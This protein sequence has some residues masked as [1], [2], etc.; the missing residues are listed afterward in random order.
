MTPSLPPPADCSQRF[1]SCR[2]VLAGER[3]NKL[4]A[5]DGAA[6]CSSARRRSG[7]RAVS[8]SVVLRRKRS[9]ARKSAGVSCDNRLMR[10]AAG[11]MRW[12][13][14]SKENRSSAAV[15]NSPS[16]TKR[17]F[18][19]RGRRNGNFRKIASQIPTRFRGHG[20]RLAVPLKQ[21][22]E[23]IP[24]RFVLPLLANRDRIDRAR[25]HRLERDG[26]SSRRGRRGL[27][28]DHLGLP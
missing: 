8:R 24:F 26:L 18:R 16:R 12:S 17:P 6:N 7:K 15:T 2:F 3:R 19:Q 9:K 27:L 13:K 25:L 21:A 11:W 1:A 20:D 5:K 23:A 22:A 4:C 10:L 28:T 14:A